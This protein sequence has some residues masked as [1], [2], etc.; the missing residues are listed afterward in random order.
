MELA[1][2]TILVEKSG[3]QYEFETADSGESIAAMFN[4][5]R[6]TLSRTVKWESQSAAK[7][8]NPELQFTGG[9]PSVLTIDL[10]F[11]TYD[12]PE[13]D[14]QSVRKYT[15]KLHSLTTV[16]KHGDKHRPPLC[17]LQWGENHVFFQGVLQQLETSYTMFLASGLP[18]RATCK[19]TFKQWI[20]NDKDLKKQDLMSSDVAKIWV[21]RRG[22]LL[23]HI[24]A[25]EYGD[26]RQWRTIAEANDIDDP[27]AV[28][29]GMRLLLPAR[30]V[31]WNPRARR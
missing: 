24:A 23:T 11:D 22:Q 19:C 1:H 28:A 20:G 25:L 9:D 14:K 17:R 6:L 30:R 21:V 8:D 27:L 12:T 7:R 2:L 31:A 26:P 4:P 18:V 3:A 15:D 16:E 10:L 13:V 5:N 29:P